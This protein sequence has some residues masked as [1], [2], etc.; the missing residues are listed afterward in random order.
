[1]PSQGFL[2][3]ARRFFAAL[4]GLYVLSI[5]LLTV[6]YIQTHVLFLHAVKIPWSAKFDVPEACGLAPNKTINLR[7]ETADHESL[8]AWF[9]LPDSY[10]HSLPEIPSEPALL[11]PDALKT[12]PTILFFHGNAATRAFSA[13]VQ[14][15]TAYSSRLGANVLALDYRGFG[16]STGNPSEAG[17]ALDA[18][19]AWNWLIQNGAT[20][21]QILILGHSLGTGVSALLASELSDEGIAPRGLVLMSP[22]SSIS[23]VLDTY[24][25]LQ[26]AP[27][28]RPLT[29][30][31]FAAD[32]VK[33]RI[34]HTFKTDTL[35]PRIKGPVLLAHAE[36]DWEIPYSHSEA[37]FNTFLEPH[38]PAI[39]SLPT[40]PTSL[41][42]EEW[43]EFSDGLA[44]YKEARQAIITSVELRN[45][46][47]IQE[48][49]ESNGRRVVYVQ[50][51]AGG[52]NYLGV[53]EG[54]HDII[55]RTF[56]FL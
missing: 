40:N 52:H 43:T 15:Y 47:T 35:V 20:A 38:L 31:P 51:L 53:Q 23:R 5:V 3:L 30:I 2:P 16:D 29:M 14:Q 6:P 34:L 12:H 26:I 4:G 42:K 11:I 50:S 25:I 8:G 39:P 17:L 22:F 44:K 7:V 46:G 45:F 54:L 24:S 27:V 19:A 36:N 18:R 56:G 41:T 9:V 48:F 55:G 13:R 1:M 37:L 49:T 10:Y 32:F 33:N 21:D 28:L